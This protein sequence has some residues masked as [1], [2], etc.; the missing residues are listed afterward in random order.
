MSG[1][2]CAGCGGQTNTALSDWVDSID[3]GKA[4]KCYAKW[5]NGKWIKGCATDKGFM[6][7]FADKIIGKKEPK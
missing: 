6:R 5:E 7:T 1:I 3:T 4:E 2:E